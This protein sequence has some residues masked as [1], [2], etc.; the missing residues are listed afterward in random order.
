MQRLGLSRP[1]WR[2]LLYAGGATALLL[3]FNLAVNL[4]WQ[5]IDPVG[6]DRINR[7]T[8]NLF[9]G[10]TTIAGAI[11]IGLAAG[12]SEELLFRGA[13]QPRLGILLA[14]VLFS[15]GHLQYGLTLA[16][17]QVFVIG[18]FVGWTRKRANTTTS[19]AIHAGYNMMIV[20]FGLL[21]T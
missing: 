8:E 14:T 1:T 4:A 15:V 16:M 19:I 10:L 17:L 12:F 6:F 9:G 20:F 18:L 13:V 5:Q 3:G 2:Q 11:V 21:Q 7:V